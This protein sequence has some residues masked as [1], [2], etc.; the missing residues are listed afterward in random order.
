[1]EKPA[2]WKCVVGDRVKFAMNKRAFQEGN[3]IIGEVA[4]RKDKFAVIKSDKLPSKVRIH[5]SCLRVIKP[6]LTTGRAKKQLAA[7]FNLKPVNRPKKKAKSEV[8]TV[9]SGMIFSYKK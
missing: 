9:V 6:V 4:E 1:M 7:G 8:T 2:S 5:V 3:L